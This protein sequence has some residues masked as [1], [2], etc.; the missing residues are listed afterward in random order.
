MNPARQQQHANVPLCM[1]VKRKTWMPALFRFRVQ[2]LQQGAFHCS[3][4]WVDMG[5]SG[6]TTRDCIL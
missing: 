2:K 5:H 1:K 6:R 3:M 4:L